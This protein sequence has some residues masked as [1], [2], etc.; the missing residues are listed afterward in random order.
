MGGRISIIVPVYKVE[1]YL[2]KCIERLWKSKTRRMQ[3][4]VGRKYH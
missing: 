3:E 2:P 1:A 4:W